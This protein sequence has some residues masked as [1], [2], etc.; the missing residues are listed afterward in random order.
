M[1]TIIKIDLDLNTQDECINQIKERINFLNK[2]G[3]IKISKIEKIQTIYK[4]TYSAKIFYKDNIKDDYH[5]ILIQSI[6]GDDWRRTS[7]TFR[8]KI[9]GIK[10]FNRLFDIKRYEN[11]EYI[12]ASSNFYNADDIK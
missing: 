5:L 7:I 6:L 8:D 11:G 4:K 2:L 10:N 1:A 12:T 9:I 3:I